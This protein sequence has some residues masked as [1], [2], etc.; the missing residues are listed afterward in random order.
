MPLPRRAPR[1]GGVEPDEP[2]DISDFERLND[3]AAPTSSTISRT[4]P[5]CGVWPKY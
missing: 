1:A 4:T 2:E 3:P 5:L